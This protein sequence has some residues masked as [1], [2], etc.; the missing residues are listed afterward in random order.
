VQRAWAASRRPESIVALGAFG[1]AALV[2][3]WIVRPFHV[4]MLG[5]DAAASVLYFKRLA[6]TGLPTA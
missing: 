4:G 6:C 5:Y 1:I 2:A 3:A